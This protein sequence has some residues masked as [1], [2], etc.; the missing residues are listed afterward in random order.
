MDRLQTGLSSL[1]PNRRGTIASG[2]AMRSGRRRQ[3]SPPIPLPSSL[4]SDKERYIGA[5]SSY[6]LGDCRCVCSQS[7]AQRGQTP[8]RRLSPERRSTI[9]AR[10]A[11]H[12]R[13]D[14]YSPTPAPAVPPGLT[15]QRPTHLEA[16]RWPVGLLLGLVLIPQRAGLC[17]AVRG[18]HSCGVCFCSRRPHLDHLPGRDS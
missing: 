6:G 1:P 16:H 2:P 11:G 7:I 18:P 13:H 4:G 3:W 17:P 9:D 15:T 8:A 10:P 14:G 5:S 12:G